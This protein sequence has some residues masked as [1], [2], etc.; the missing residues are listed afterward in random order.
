MAGQ[1]VVVSNTLRLR[2]SPS[3][4]GSANVITQMNKGQVLAG[5]RT[6]Y[7]DVNGNPWVYGSPL[8]TKHAGYAM[9]EDRAT[10]EKFLRVGG[11]VEGGEEPG[12]GPGDG[13]GL[14]GETVQ[15]SRKLLQQLYEVVGGWL[16]VE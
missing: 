14:V 13:E 5:V 16:G 11:L 6:G 1:A 7:S 3:A 2:K 12:G 8:G 15:V 10:G 4:G 9:V